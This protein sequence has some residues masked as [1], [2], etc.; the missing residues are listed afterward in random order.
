M[1]F[2]I[3]PLCFFLGS[4]QAPTG[5][6]DDGGIWSEHEDP[7]ARPDRIKTFKGFVAK[8]PVKGHMVSLLNRPISVDP[9]RLC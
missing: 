8:E 2:L 3:S 7:A 1:T 4:P 6:M 9:R 5:S